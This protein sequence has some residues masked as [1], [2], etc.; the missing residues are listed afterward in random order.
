MSRSPWVAVVAWSA[1]ILLGTSLPGSVLPPAFPHADKLV[2][3]ALYGTLGFL[4]ARALAAARGG[5]AARRLALAL[6]AIAG[7]AAFD[8]WHQDFVPR[9]SS[10]RLDWLADVV[11]ATAG[12]VV[13]TTLRSE[14]RI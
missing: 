4:T 2:H 5:L 1:A 9:R 8:E 10:D 7:F 12:L 11:G 3:A 14:Q 6:A 13:T